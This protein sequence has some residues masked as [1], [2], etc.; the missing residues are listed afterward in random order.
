MII[1]YESLG[2][3]IHLVKNIQ[4]VFNTYLHKNPINVVIKNKQTDILNVS[5]QFQISDHE[6]KD[7]I[8]RKNFFIC[9]SIRRTFV[10]RA[11]SFPTQEKCIESETDCIEDRVSIL[12]LE[13]DLI[14][15]INTGRIVSVSIHPMDTKLVQMR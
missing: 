4:N 6:F 13:K 9:S 2:I 12:R 1:I 15:G 3:F 14:I 5:M 7:Q 11:S 8:S 10:F